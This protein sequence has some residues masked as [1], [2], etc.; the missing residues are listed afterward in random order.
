[1]VGEPPTGNG[2]ASL[3]PTPWRGHAFTTLWRSSPT[4]STRLASRLV[5]RR[6]TMSTF[7]SEGR[8][9]YRGIGQL[10]AQLHDRGLRPERVGYCASSLDRSRSGNR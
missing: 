3:V 10:H 7:I 2:A 4:V 8:T 1:M 5:P 9:L 6:K